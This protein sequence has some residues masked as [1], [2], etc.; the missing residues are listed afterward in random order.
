[1]T[2]KQAGLGKESN[3]NT[4]IRT[5]LVL[6]LLISL[7]ILTG[8]SSQSQEGS[9]MKVWGYVVAE[10]NAALELAE[11]QPGA[12]ELVVDR[13]LSPG[14]AWLVVHADDNGMP[15][16]RVGIAHVDAGTSTEVRVTLEGVTTDKVIVAVHADKG[17]AGEFDFDMMNKETSPDRPYFVNEKELAKVVN[18]R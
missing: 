1:M 3:M 14:A 8:C 6:A 16:E 7:A 9:G 11:R 12:S 10:K 2:P 5:G 17:I 18:V 13:V 15:G 4:T